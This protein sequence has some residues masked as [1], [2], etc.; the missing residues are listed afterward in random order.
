MAEEEKKEEKKSAKE[1]ASKALKVILGLVLLAGGIALIYFWRG[2]VLNLIK[3][4]IGV[5]VLLAGVVCLAI[6][7]E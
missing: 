3:G 5:I 2:D 1:V 6:A 4:S 7:K